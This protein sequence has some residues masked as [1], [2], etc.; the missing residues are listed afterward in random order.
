MRS[1]KFTIEKPYILYRLAGR[2]GQIRLVVDGYMMDNFTPLLFEGL[3][4]KVDTNGAMQWHSQS[5]EKY[6][7]HRAHIEIIDAGDG[8][9]AVD[10]ICFASSSTSPTPDDS[11]TR[12]ILAQHNVASTE[13]LAKAYG[14]LLAQSLLDWREGKPSA[15]AEFVRWAIAHQLLPGSDVVQAQ[16][17]DL[18]KQAAAI[19]T[20]LPDP[21]KVVAIADGS[22]EDQPVHIRGNYK[23]PG[24]VVPRRLLEAIAGAEQPALSHGSGR[25]ELAER[26]LSP[27]NPFTARVMANRVWQHLFGQGI[28]ATVDN[29]GVLGERP[30]HPELLDYLATRFRGDGWSI[31]KLIREIMLSQAYQLASDGA[32]TSEQHDPRNLLLHRANVR[33]LEGEAIRDA[34]LAVS[35]RL[36]RTQF[37]P[38]IRIHLSPFMEGR[39]RPE[40]SGPLDGA[41]RRSVYIEVRRN[42]LSPFMLA[43]DTPQPAS[44]A[45][46]RNVSNVPAQALSMMNDP[47]V[48]EQCEIWARRALAEEDCGPEDR[49]TNLYL[50][51]FGRPPSTEERNEAASFLKEQAKIHVVGMEDY[52]PWADLC[53]VLV[54][55]KEFVFIR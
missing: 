15:G 41:A 50:A 38:S 4:F 48:I 19:D 14:D 52:R 42:F 36:D 40:Q 8:F 49:I 3:T 21:L 46:R 18:A 7:D 13:T 29:F 37:G 12:L 54:N 22:A 23:T 27:D 51:A 44:T 10:E 16:L 2:N 34:L 43:F 47:F 35:G 20:A 5:V 53:H 1:G 17:A 55:V 28:V 25:L 11:A 24:E 30:T 6:R 26:M 45:G 39:G 31:K 33:R 9:V 32:E